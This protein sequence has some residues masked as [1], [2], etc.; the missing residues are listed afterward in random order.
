MTISDYWALSPVIAMAGL[1]VVVLAADAS[2]NE[3]WLG[4]RRWGS[5]SWLVWIASVG[6]LLPLFFTLNLWFG[7]IGDASEGATLFGTFT[8]DRFTLFFQFLIIGSTAA[9][10]IASA[11]YLVQFSDSRG[12]F[13]G[14]MLCSAAGMLLLVGASELITIYVALE[15]TALPIVA[16]AAIRRDGYS[17]EAG[18]KFLILSALSTAVLL[19]GFVFLYGFTGATELSE[20]AARVG[21]LSTD[22]DEPFGS[23][24]VLFSIVL[25][26]AGFGFKMAIA[27]WQM[28]VPDVYQGS[29]TPVAAFL[30]V[31]SKASA[32][33]VLMRLLYV[34]LGS[35]HMIQD[36]QIFFA[37]IAAVSMTFG[38]LLAL[39]Q[40]NVKRILAYSTIAQAGYIM[41]GLAAVSTS[42]ASGSDTAGI[43]SVLYYL[44]GYAFTNLA[45]FLAYTAVI[46]RSGDVTI[47]GLSGLFRR[48][49]ILALMLVLGLLSLL[50]MPP[51]VGFMTKAVIFSTA[52]DQGLLWLA[53]IAVLNT[54]VA[55][56]YYLRLVGTIMFGEPE[57]EEKLSPGANELVVVG[58]GVA[59]AIVLGVVPMF[60]L[61]FV[62]S[63]ITIL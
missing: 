62:D 24:I 9:V 58:A 20:I 11:R 36:W 47:A 15:T 59:G 1:A 22:S 8:A 2:L 35:D 3:R 61:D 27:P 29:P 51:T 26:V 12:E 56:Y 16:L 7:W 37:V 41:V 55:A 32:F 10:A 30:S 43:Q 53:V 39:S 13:L 42:S 25:I 49:P 45:V 6:L 63:S 60:I 17:I 33:A 40:N 31:A 23:L 5:K 19:F 4:G 46:H 34:A 54:V 21:E 50:G 57:D 28:W 48:S 38:N 18:A 44:A 14:L 52:V